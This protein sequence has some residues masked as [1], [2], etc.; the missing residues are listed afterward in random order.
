VDKATA[1]ERVKVD[2][3]VSDADIAEHRHCTGAN[4]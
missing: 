4:D 1:V 2:R 3:A